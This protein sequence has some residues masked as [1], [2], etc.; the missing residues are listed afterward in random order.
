M[1]QVFQSMKHSRCSP[2]K[3]KLFLSMRYGDPSDNEVPVSCEAATKKWTASPGV[4]LCSVW[5]LTK[6]G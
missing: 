4:A 1:H 2:G 5:P 3:T 6:V